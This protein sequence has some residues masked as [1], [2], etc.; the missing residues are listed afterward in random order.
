MVTLILVGDIRFSVLR[1]SNAKGDPS[2]S[3]ASKIP[4]AVGALKHAWGRRGET[5]RETGRGSE[6]G[7]GRG[8]ERRGR[9]HKKVQT[10]VTISVT[11]SKY[12]DLA[13]ARR[14]GSDGSSRGSG[15]AMHR[16]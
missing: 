8:S 2:P 14:Y 15:R 3:R 11:C 10:V 9:V 7:T 16:H 13:L 12:R 5:G 4:S 1:V 6:R